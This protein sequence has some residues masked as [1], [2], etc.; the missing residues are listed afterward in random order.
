MLK[1]KVKD[2]LDNAGSEI[3]DSFF[4]SSALNYLDDEDAAKEFQ[5]KADALCVQFEFKDNFGGGGM[6]EDYWSV[7]V[8]TDGDE[9]VYVKFDGWYQSYNGSEYTDWSFVQPKEVTVTKWKT[10]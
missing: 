1:D 7:Y 5:D 9:T 3:L 10:A 4:E 6:G 8:F 2:L